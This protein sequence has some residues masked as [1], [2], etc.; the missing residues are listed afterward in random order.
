MGVGD[1]LQPRRHDL[2]DVERDET[3]LPIHDHHI[4]IENPRGKV[5]TL[6]CVASRRD[7]VEREID[8]DDVA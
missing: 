5:K 2:L 8:H 1:S 7:I 6:S 3:T 4:L